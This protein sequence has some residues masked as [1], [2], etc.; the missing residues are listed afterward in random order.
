MDFDSKCCRRSLGLYV[1]ALVLKEVCKVSLR[2]AEAAK[3]NLKL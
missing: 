2:Y 3:L 1:K